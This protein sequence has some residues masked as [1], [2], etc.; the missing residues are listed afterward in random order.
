MGEEGCQSDFGTWSKAVCDLSEEK[1]ASAMGGWET[2]R[3][4]STEGTRQAFWNHS[5]FQREEMKR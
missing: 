5:G 4:I 3:L 2:K 1:T